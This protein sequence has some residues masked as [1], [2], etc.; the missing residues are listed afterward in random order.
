MTVHKDPTQKEGNN[1][2]SREPGKEVT[3]EQTF[4]YSSSPNVLPLPLLYSASHVLMNVVSPTIKFKYYIILQPT[5]SCVNSSVLL[6]AAPKK[7]IT[8][9][10]SILLV[11]L[12][13]TKC[14][15][16]YLQK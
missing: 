8:N 1:L 6:N 9:T 14:N 3:L 7:F 12:Y 4:C 11:N 16:I 5:H 13:G 10:M 2:S 15:K